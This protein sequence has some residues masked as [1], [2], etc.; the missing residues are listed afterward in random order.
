MYLILYFYAR[1]ELYMIRYSII[2]H[3]RVQGVGFRYFTAMQAMKFHLNGW[4]RNMSNG[5]VSIEIQGLENDISSFI[6]AIKKGNGF[7]IVD[8]IELNKI[9]I[10]DNC[11]RYRIM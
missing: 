7:C 4:C 1:K 6:T 5:T 11:T 10:E 9:P 8:E 2:V 3:G